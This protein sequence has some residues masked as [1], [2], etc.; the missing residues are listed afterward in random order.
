MPP[1]GDDCWRALV[2]AAA[3]LGV[4]VTASAEPPLVIGRYTTDSCVCPHGVAYWVEPT[5]EQIAQWVRD[6][7]S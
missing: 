5:G 1:P 4:E 7:V 2:D 3:G 6:G